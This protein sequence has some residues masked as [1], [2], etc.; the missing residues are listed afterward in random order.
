MC[1]SG[2]CS[3]LWYICQWLKNR[4]KIGCL[5]EFSSTILPIFCKVIMN[6]RTGAWCPRKKYCCKD[7]S[8]IRVIK[9]HHDLQPVTAHR[10]TVN[11]KGSHAFLILLVSPIL[12]AWSHHLHWCYGCSPSSISQCLKPKPNKWCYSGAIFF[13]GWESV[14]RLSVCKEL[15]I[16]RQLD[17]VST[18]PRF[19]N[20]NLKRSH[21]HAFCSKNPS[22]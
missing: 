8:F 13:S 9:F 18:S 1:P 2:G 7:S 5:R 3:R 12:T 17:K 19:E 15:V 14:L 20:V 4:V 11:L 16:K 21:F 10:F 22:K 6:I